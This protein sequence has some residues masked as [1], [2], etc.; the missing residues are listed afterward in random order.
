M[1][2][3]NVLHFH[4]GLSIGKTFILNI[5]LLSQHTYTKHPPPRQ[6]NGLK[7]FFEKGILLHIKMGYKYYK[8]TLEHIY[9]KVSKQYKVA[10]MDLKAVYIFTFGIIKVDVFLTKDICT[11]FHFILNCLYS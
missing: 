11:I 2:L 1:H 4:S 10:R 8:S 5:L 6:L 9:Q 7:R 3:C